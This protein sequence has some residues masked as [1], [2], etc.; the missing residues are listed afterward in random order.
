MSLAGKTMVVTGGAG[1]LGNAVAEVARAQ[2]AEVVLLDAHRILEPY[3]DARLEDWYWVN[4]HLAQLY[5]SS[6]REP[7]AARFQSAV[8]ALSN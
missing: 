4:T 7:E 3:R 6:G 2:G 5:V 8:A 1:V